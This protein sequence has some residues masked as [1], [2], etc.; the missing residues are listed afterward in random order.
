MLTVSFASFNGTDTLPLM[1]EALTRVRSPSGGWR[2]V[3]VDNASTDETYELL[4][5]YRG[6][7]PITVLQQPE[8]GKSKALNL[9]LEY[10]E[11]D[12]LVFTDDDVVPEADW[13]VAWRNYADQ[14]PEYG[15]FGGTIRPFWLQTPPAW[16]LSAIPLGIAYAQTHKS[17][18]AGKVD[19]LYIAGPNMAVRIEAVRSGLR[20]DM[21]KGPSGTS[22]AMGEDTAFAYAAQVFGYPAAHCPDAVIQHIVHPAQYDKSW[23]LRRA[24]R[25]GQSRAAETILAERE[26]HG[27]KLMHMPRWMLREYLKQQFLSVAGWLSGNTASHMAAAW[28][29]RYLAGYLSEYRR[30]RKR[31]AVD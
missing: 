4:L 26:L 20:F 5:S 6:R 7:L 25:Y 22:Y 19:P 21:D 18:T 29:A 16:I 30:Q 9:A 17:L 13:L 31:Q 1:L 12:L 11:G 10:A 27:S 23:L 15:I 14:H 8:K 3:A 28:E 2:L 24:Y